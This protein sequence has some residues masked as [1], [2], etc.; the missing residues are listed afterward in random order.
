[1]KNPL[2]QDFLQNKK[3][4]CNTKYLQNDDVFISINGGFKYLDEETL[5]K[6]SCI[7]LDEHDDFEGHG[8]IIKCSKLNDNYLQWLDE[9]FSIDHNQFN[10]FFVTGTNG[11]TTTTHFLSDILTANNIDHGSVGTLGTF[12]NKALV[13]QNQLTTE[14]PTYIRSFLNACNK[15][16]IDKVLFEASSIGIDQGRLDGMPIKHVVYLN[17]SRDHFDYHRN[18]ESYL[19]AK[20]KLIENE[21][22]ETLVF[23]ADQPEFIDSLSSVNAKDVF[24]ISNRNKSADIFYE[25]KN[26]DLTGNMKFKARTPWGEFNAEAKILTEYNIFNLLASLPYFYSVGGDVPSFFHSLS[27]LSLPEGR[28]QKINERPIYIDYAHTP[29]AL[30]QACK[31][32]KNQENKLILVFGAGGDRDTGK[33]KQMGEVADKYAD[34]IIVTSDNPRNEDPAKIADMIIEGISKESKIHI[35]LDRSKAISRAID[36]MDETSTLLVCGKGHE[37]NQII[38]NNKFFFSDKE[39]IIKCI[40]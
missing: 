7:I 15:K 30:E 21:E 17:L 40:N 32:L 26:C 20:R 24:Q 4:T 28:L 27:S 6:A 29:H 2:K 9:L 34:E 39:E 22:L 36:K 8:K 5:K 19:Q 25:I 37:K 12:V 13:F 33:R 16:N 18:Y 35:E 14:E 11:K 23:N 3:F 31:S 1:M 10:N 38:G